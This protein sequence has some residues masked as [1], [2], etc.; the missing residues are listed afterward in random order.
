MTTPP[1]KPQYL[2]PTQQELRIIFSNY[3]PL[4]GALF[5][6]NGNRAGSVHKAS[7]YRVVYVRGKYLPEQKVVWC[8]N[9]GYYPQNPIMHKDGNRQNNTLGNLYQAHMSQGKATSRRNRSGLTGVS[10]FERTK[11]W[12][13]TIYLPNPVHI[14]YYADLQAAKQAR[15]DA[16][17]RYEQ[18]K[19]PPNTTGD[20]EHDAKTG[21]EGA[22][23]MRPDAGASKAEGLNK[24]EGGNAETTRSIPVQPQQPRQPD[25]VPSGWT[26]I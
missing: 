16:Y 21:T 10:W 25:A 17:R 5:Y 3:D 9:H 4:T 6:I 8:Y 13:V 2:P 7:G 15:I 26:K 23:I 18:K 1:K 19:A 12:R 24:A 11:R 22:N 14:G 20:W